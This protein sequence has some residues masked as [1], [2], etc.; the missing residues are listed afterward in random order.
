[1]RGRRA[2][3]LAI[4]CVGLAYCTVIQPIGWNQASHYALI[5]SI[6]AH[7]PRIDRYA[8]STGDRARYQGH[9]YSSRAPG[10]ATVSVPL[11]EAFERVGLTSHYRQRLGGRKNSEI[12]WL[13]GIWAATLPAVVMM[14]LV[15][16]I[17]DRLEPGY[18]VLAAVT[19]GLGT[20]VLP[21]GTML[22]SHVLSAAL[23]FAAFAL[24]FRERMNPERRRLWP[25]A[26]A[27]IGAGYAV[28]VEYPLLFVGIVLGVY[29]VTMGDA[30]RRG[31]L[32][33]A[34]AIVGIVPLAVYN[35]WAFGTVTHVAYAD[36]P[37]QQSGFFGIQVPDPSVAIQLLLSSRGLL[38]LAPVLA[39]GIAGTVIL[40]RRG[41]RAEAAV[42]AAVGLIFLAYNS[43]YYLPYGGRVPG[44]RFLI[45]TLPFLAL[46]LGIAY[47]RFP[48]PTVALGAISAMTLGVATMTEPL[49]SAEGD[50]GM[51]THQ[52]FTGHLQPTFV[53]IWRVH[54]QWLVTAPFLAALLL[55]IVIAVRAAPRLR[56]GWR[57]VAT[58]AAVAG[59]WTL[60][61]IFAPH[62]LGIDHA[63]ERKIVEAG[64]PTAV[65]NAYGVHPLVDLALMA[66]GAALV[67][68][69]GARLVTARRPLPAEAPA[70]ER[71]TMV[72][73]AAAAQGDR[74]KSTVS[75]I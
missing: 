48:G 13:L 36:I 55:G 19:L 7:T 10:L 52:L 60:F 4:A 8:G 29:A 59:A 21:F 58:G 68:L 32:Y 34:G 20:L 26:L 65:F 49:V 25:F 5:R 63:A 37:K 14:F 64:D 53:K 23:G 11:Y 38:T 70:E 42:I 62:L 73:P 22:F 61:A 67:C 24:L 45:A 72:G 39:M 35:L 27:G 54:D 28:T 46:P 66:L 3:L 47:R 1:M 75:P 17:G 2:A 74:L 69:L 43:G 57:S 50:V 56:V 71:E 9:W 6:D 12:V 16:R 51:W 15:Y 41:N 18:G 33:L 31:A 40:Y 44:P 30:V